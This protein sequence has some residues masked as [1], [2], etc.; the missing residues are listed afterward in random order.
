MKFVVIMSLFLELN[1]QKEKNSC[2]K[3]QNAKCFFF[4]FTILI[5]HTHTKIMSE[6]GFRNFFF[7]EKK[8]LKF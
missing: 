7:C 5:P 2:Q 8:E 3:T 4:S 6:V 1:L